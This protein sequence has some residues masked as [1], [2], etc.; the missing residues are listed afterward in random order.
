MLHGRNLLKEKLASG[1]A[2]AGL[3]ITI[4]SPH[5]TELAGTMGFDWVVIDAEHGHLD[6]KEILEHLRALRGSPTTPL[7]R[8]PEI[9]G[10]FIKRVLDLGA[11][12]ILVPQVTSAQDV[13]AA[14]GFAK[15]P[16]WGMR[17][18]C[19]DR[20]TQWGANLKAYTECAND[21]ILVLPIIETVAAADAIE[22]ILAVT[23]VDAMIFGPA[24]F[25]ASM[26]HL[27]QWEG[28]GVAKRS[29]A[30]PSIGTPFKCA[31]LTGR[32]T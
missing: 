6:F 13:T 26:G 14:V 20:A 21:E 29:C 5:L 27:G 32:E 15:Y 31:L 17:G 30:R 22:D 24:D 23:G 3:W 7:V 10:G 1:I 12:G 11:E 4:E 8:I 25:S 9:S 28:P 19:A 16:P 18:V 2:A